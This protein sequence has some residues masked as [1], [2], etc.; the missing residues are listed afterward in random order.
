VSKLKFG[1]NEKLNNVLELF[2]RTGFV[3]HPGS[4]A[5]TARDIGCELICFQLFTGI[6]PSTSPQRCT[7]IRG[8]AS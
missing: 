4:S 7:Y 3:A 6:K 8:V 5:R 2:A 1:T